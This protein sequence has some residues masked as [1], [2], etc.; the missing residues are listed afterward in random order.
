LVLSD[1]AFDRAD[2]LYKDNQNF[3][4]RAEVAYQRGYLLSQKGELKRSR[5]LA[6]QALEVAKLADNKY[7]QVKALLLLGAIA[8][9]AGDTAQGQE[10]ANQGLVLAQNNDM[11]SLTTQ[12][13]LDLGYALMVKRSYID[14]EK[15]LKQGAEL[16][17]RYREKRNEAR[18][19]LLLGTLYMQKEDP[20]KGA[21]FIDQALTFYRSGGYRREISRCMMMVGRQQLLKRNFDDALKTLDEQLQL[22][23]LV[24]DP[25][26]LARSQAEVAAALSKQDLYPQALVRYTESYESNKQ[27]KNPLNTAF[28]LLNRGDMLARLGRDDEA[29]AALQELK[30]YLDPL[31]DDNNY[32]VLWTIW[33]HLIRG[34]MALRSRHFAEAKDEC[35]T[36]LALITPQNTKALGTSEVEVKGLLGLA[37]VYL[38]AT[39]AG[40]RVCEQAAANSS[41]DT[42]LESAEAG[43]RLILAEALVE[44]GESRRASAA[45]AEAQ[46]MFATSHRMEYEW[47]AWVIAARASQQLNDEQLQ[48][49]QLSRSH[50]LLNAL[51]AK[52]GEEAFD[53]YSARADIQAFRRQMVDLN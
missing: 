53:S 17:L 20:D 22:A 37:Q 34:Q 7:Q 40:R 30:T 41:A 14:S 42:S 46:Q 8:Y 44:I 3:E 5:E 16:A 9:S 47:R 26:Q 12:G 10:L 28:A 49:E 23:K 43:L 50:T 24:E 51:R 19:N 15:H 29:N 48:R 11:E 31:S 21:P 45:A 25:G 38:G 36:A 52:W 4:G 33:S 32:K 13:L 6:Q 2:E 27:L 35:E 39:A 18:A 1:A